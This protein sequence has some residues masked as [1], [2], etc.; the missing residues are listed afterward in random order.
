MKILAEPVIY[1]NLGSKGLNKLS[2]THLLHLF[3][4]YY[5]PHVTERIELT[6]KIPKV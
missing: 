4:H 3:L 1:G 6:S 5:H 2:S